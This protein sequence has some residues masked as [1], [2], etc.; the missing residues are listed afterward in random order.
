[1]HFHT[2][3]LRQSYKGDCHKMEKRIDAEETIYDYMENEDY[4]IRFHNQRSG[5]PMS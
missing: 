4:K 1:M 2:N 3:I 5:L